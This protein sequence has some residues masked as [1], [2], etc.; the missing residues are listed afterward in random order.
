MYI[1]IYIKKLYIKKF[2]STSKQKEGA[3]G[4]KDQ[5]KKTVSL[6]KEPQKNNPILINETIDCNLLNGLYVD[7]VTDNRRYRKKASKTHAAIVSG[8]PNATDLNVE[9]KDTKVNGVPHKNKEGINL[10]SIFE[11]LLRDNSSKPQETLSLPK[12]CTDTFLSGNTS[13][14]LCT[15]ENLD[16]QDFEF[17]NILEDLLKSS[18]D[19]EK[20]V[21]R[22]EGKTNDSIQNKTSVTTDESTLSGYFCSETVFNLSNSRN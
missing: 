17:L 1:Y 18:D 15:S 9:M 22:A 3:I 7:N 20:P 4:D 10:T 13:S 2:T 11:N 21:E 12:I 8:T 16:N 14:V 6:L 5:D 19:F